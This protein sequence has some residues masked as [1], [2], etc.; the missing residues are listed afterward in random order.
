MQS[1]QDDQTQPDMASLLRRHFVSWG[2]TRA[3][4]LKK[5]LSYFVTFGSRDRHGGAA[6]QANALMPASSLCRVSTS[7]QSGIIHSGSGPC[8][9]EQIAARIEICELGFGAATLRME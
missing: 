9:A 7:S 2:E 6:E 3:H 4:N 5:C 1:N 8:A